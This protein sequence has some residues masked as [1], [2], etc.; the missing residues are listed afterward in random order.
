V[1]RLLK[2]A[3]NAVADQSFDPQVGMPKPDEHSYSRQYIPD[4]T[5]E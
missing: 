5:P 4:V 2:F 3:A 1:T